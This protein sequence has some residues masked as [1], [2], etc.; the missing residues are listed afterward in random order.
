MKSSTLL[1]T[2]FALTWTSATSNGVRNRRIEVLT[3]GDRKLLTKKLTAEDSRANRWWWKKND[4]K[5]KKTSWTKKM[6]EPV[7]VRTHGYVDYGWCSIFR[8][9]SDYANYCKRRDR[10]FNCTW[11]G[12]GTELSNACIEHDRC[13]TAHHKCCDDGSCD[14]IP[15]DVTSDAKIKCHDSLAKK[16]G[17]ISG[18]MAKTVSLAMRALS[19]SLKAKRFF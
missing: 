13:M 11:S 16:A 10:K 9:G 3:K 12:C 2:L 1:L 15:I 7:V 5:G 4:G 19:F 8:V 18:S 17:E 14:G 6:L